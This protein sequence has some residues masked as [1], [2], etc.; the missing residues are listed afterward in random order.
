MAKRKYTFSMDSPI[1]T[2]EHETNTGGC[3]CVCVSTHETNAGGYVCVCVC[4][5]VPLLSCL[6]SSQ[7]TLCKKPLGAIL[8]N[9]I[10][11]SDMATF[12][13]FFFGKAVSFMRLL[14]MIPC[15]SWPLTL[16]AFLFLLYFFNFFSS[17][18]SVTRS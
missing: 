1:S 4:L 2:S 17:H 8:F 14:A 13:F 9:K 5:S 10:S 18:S 7:S 15:F 6:V 16:L 12:F 3:V 11:K